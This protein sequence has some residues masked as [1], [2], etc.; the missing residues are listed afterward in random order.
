MSSINFRR[1][2]I[3]SALMILA[4][5]YAVLWLG[6][7]GDP[8]QRTGTDFIASYSAAGV[9][10]RYGISRVYDLE[11]QQA[12]QA[13]VVG[14]DLAPG[15]VLMYN[16]IPYLV[17][18]LILIVNG[19]YVASLLRYVL[20]LLTFYAASLAVINWLL[21]R[22]EWKRLMRWLL[23]AGLATFYPLFISLVNPQETAFTFFGAC[24]FLAGILTGRDWLAGLG[25]ALTTVRPH[26]TLLLAVP[27]LFRQIKVFGWFSLF[28][29]ILG[30]LCVAMLGLDG[31]RTY[32]DV[33]FTSA[34]GTWFGLH[35]PQMVNLV[36]LLWRIVPG[37][38]E[39]VIHN[40]GWVVYG[41][42]LLGL[43]ILWR[44]SSVITGKQIGMAVILTLFAVPH[45]HY[46]DLALLL[47][48]LVALL[49]VLVKGNFLQ[50]RDAVLV[51]FAF[52]LVLL[53]ASFIPAVKYNAP[54]LIML[55]MLM[56]FI[57]PRKFTFQR[58]EVE[59]QT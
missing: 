27:F 45:L 36:G 7:I 32:L 30:L 29:G 31:T 12:I 42:T 11:L 47:V 19:D 4:V 56:G 16:H 14:F 59:V 33:L 5:V 41:L 13:E 8:A 3:I 44:R 43:C 9:A 28:A 40:I 57:F 38:G 22:D 10:Q 55:L 6:M 17:P 24:L 35:E 51:P 48:A 39:T 37:L 18:M 15:Q 52:S 53:L 21:R 23:L 50:P 46:H 34:G 2:F 25:L 26:I 58:R 54:F 49:M 1:I 20:I